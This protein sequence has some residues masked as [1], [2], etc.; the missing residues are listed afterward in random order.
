MSQ[1]SAKRS[2]PPYTGSMERSELVAEVVERK[3]TPGAWGVE[4]INPSGD[5]EIF[6]AVFYGPDAHNLA[7]EYAGAKYSARSNSN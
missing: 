6:M 1:S 4:A 3:D 5:G 7:L 2:E